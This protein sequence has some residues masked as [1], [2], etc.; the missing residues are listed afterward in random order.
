MTSTITLIF[1]VC[2]CFNSNSS[3]AMQRCLITLLPCP[4]ARS[5]WF[6]FKLIHNYHICSVGFNFCPYFC[7]CNHYHDNGSKGQQQG[8]KLKHYYHLCFW[9]CKTKTKTKT[10][11]KQTNKGN[12]DNG[13]RG[14]KGKSGGDKGLKGRQ[15]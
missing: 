11:N 9:L 1:E 10:T 7:L 15:R 14:S 4:V 6:Q 5:Y 3:L 12:S 13:C 2:Y 8:F